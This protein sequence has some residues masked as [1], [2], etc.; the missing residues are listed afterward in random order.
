MAALAEKLLFNTTEVQFSCR[1]IQA[2][3]PELNSQSREP[4]LLSCA[5]A[6]HSPVSI[7]SV[8]MTVPVLI[9]LVKEMDGRG[10]NGNTLTLWGYNL[11]V[12]GINLHTRHWLELDHNTTFK[13]VWE[14][15]LAEPLYAQ[16]MIPLLSN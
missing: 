15:C 4:F 10:R 16:L 6:I 1:E 9:I 8:E 12:M 13:G 14:L 11:E 5:A 3:C 7:S 2:G